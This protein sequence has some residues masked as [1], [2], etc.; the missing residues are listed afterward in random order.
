MTLEIGRAAPDFALPDQHGQETSLSSFLG[1]KSVTVLFYPYAFS[2]ICTSELGELRDDLAAFRGETAELL[3]V[4][5]DHMFSLR[6][7]AERDGLTYPL[8]SD[9]WPHGEV[10]RAYGVFD[11]QRGAAVRGTFLVDREGLLRW[12]LVNPIGTGRDLD[13]LRLALRDLAG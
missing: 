1:A 6:A 13:D 4:S 11:E 2:G 8:L 3:A 12:Q 7:Y 10:S 9:F 5:C